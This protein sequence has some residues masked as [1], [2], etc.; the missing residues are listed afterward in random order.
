MAGRSAGAAAGGIGGRGRP[1]EA[2]RQ[3]E[4]PEPLLRPRDTKGTFGVA[5]RRQRFGGR[6]LC[7]TARFPPVLPRRTMPADRLAG[8][9][10]GTA[11]GD[12]LGLPRENLSP[13]RAA[14]LFPGPVRHGLLPAV[15]PV[16]GNRWRGMVSDDTEHTVLSALGPDRGADRPGAL[17]PRPRPAVEVVAGRRPLRV[18]QSDADRLRDRPRT[19]PSG[20]SRSGLGKATLIACAKLCVGVPPDRSGAPSAGNGPVMRAALPGVFFLNDPERRRAF[21]RGLR[22]A[23]AHRSAGRRRGANHRPRRRPRRD[24]GGGTRPRRDAGGPR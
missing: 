18:G 11:V 7:L 17:R 15:R 12:A 22:P 1:P 4:R 9:L 20:A 3:R 24:P 14:R 13:R 23:D 19:R 8:C 21:G 6:G 16:G 2:R 10:L 5:G